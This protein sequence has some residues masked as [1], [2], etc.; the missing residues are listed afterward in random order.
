MKKKEIIEQSG[1]DKWKGVAKDEVEANEINE[2]ID[3]EG[4][5]NKKKK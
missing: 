4:M 5:I 3:F 1:T 2:A